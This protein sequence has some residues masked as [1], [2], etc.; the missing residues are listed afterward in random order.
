MSELY[1]EYEIRS[2]LLQAGTGQE[3]LHI[4][5][6]VCVKLAPFTISVLTGA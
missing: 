2:S 1:T 3:S 4:D 5:M 6:Y